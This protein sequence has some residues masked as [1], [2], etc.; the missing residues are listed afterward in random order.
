MLLGCLKTKEVKRLDDLKIEKIY[1]RLKETYPIFKDNDWAFN[2]T[3]NTPFQSL[4]SVTLSAMTNSNRL[5]QACQGLF[6]EVSTPEELLALSD[7]HLRDLIRPVAHYNRKTIQLKEM[8]QQ[9]LDRHEGEVPSTREELLALK[10]VGRKSVDII[11]NFTFGEETI[12]VDTHVHR[13]LNRLGLVKT[14]TPLETA[15]VVTEVTPKKFRK[16]AHEWLVLHGMETCSARS[17]KCGICAVQDLCE[18][19]GKA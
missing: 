3:R 7:D 13:V 4:V 19:E 8:C 5:V 9:L 6:A 2:P 11:M 10:G 18:Y 17:P 15:D 1:Y 14:N 12:A 16:H